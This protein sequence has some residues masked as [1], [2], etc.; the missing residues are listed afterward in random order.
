MML[1]GPAS[2]ATALMFL[3]LCVSGQRWW[4]QRVSAFPIYLNAWMFGPA[5]PISDTLRTDSFPSDNLFH[6]K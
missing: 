4:K 6:I 1:Q 2:L 5:L 3:A